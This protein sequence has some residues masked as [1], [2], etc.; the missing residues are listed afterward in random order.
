MHAFAFVNES[1]LLQGNGFSGGIHLYALLSLIT[2]LRTRFRFQ[3]V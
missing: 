2:E 1:I 3:V